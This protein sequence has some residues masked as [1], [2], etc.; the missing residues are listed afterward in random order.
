M[1]LRRQLVFDDQMKFRRRNLLQIPGIGEKIPGGV[2]FDGKLL[3][4]VQAKEVAPHRI[5]PIAGSGV[6]IVFF[7]ST[8]KNKAAPV[9]CREL[10]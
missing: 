2:Q 8:G 4:C 3:G 9:M 7:Q 5:L 10:G 6:N 1:H